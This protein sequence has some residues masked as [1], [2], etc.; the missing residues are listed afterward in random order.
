MRSDLLQMGGA[1]AAAQQAHCDVRVTQAGSTQELYITA[2][3][4]EGEE[5]GAQAE[6]MYGRI[7]QMLRDADAV[8]VA[9]RLFGSREAMPAAMRWRSQMYRELD[10]GVQP[11]LLTDG[12]GNRSLIGAQVHAVRGIEMPSVIASEGLPVARHF[13]WKRRHY[14]VASGLRA[15]QVSTAPSQANAVFQQAIDS[16]EN[17]GG[18]FLDVARTWIWMRDILRWYGDLNHVRTKNFKKHGVI[19]RAPASTGIGIAPV[20]GHL[21]LDLFAAWGEP[22]LVQKLDAT[23][24]QRAA[25]EYGSAFARAAR[26]RTPG[27]ETVFCC[28]TAAIDAS[29]ATCFAGDIA[30]QVQ[31]TLENVAAVLRDSDCDGDDVVQAMVYC[32][33]PAVARH[34]NRVHQP[35]LPWPCLVMIGDVCRPDLLFELEVTASAR[36]RAMTFSS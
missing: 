26:V 6:A 19:G 28:G 12:S 36:A 33:T 5:P 27:G 30:R 29:G 35:Y 10:D 2:F 34:F 3:P 14:L 31:M 21:A 32:A 9:E 15:S 13:Q 16:I 18:R 4:P 11:T 7:A 1:S 22:A 25:S 24:R 20:A 8:I 17:M 23:G